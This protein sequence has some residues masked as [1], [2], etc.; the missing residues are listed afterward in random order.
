M[1]ASMNIPSIGGFLSSLLK[2]RMEAKK[3]IK[4][5]SC[6]EYEFK[7][8][9]YIISWKLAW[10]FSY[11]EKASLCIGVFFPRSQSWEMTELGLK[12]LCTWHWQSKSCFCLVLFSH[13]IFSLLK[14][15]GVLKAEKYEPIKCRKRNR[16]L[17]PFGWIWG[18]RNVFTGVIE[19][20]TFRNAEARCCS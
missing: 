4:H 9:T 10:S 17:T 14:I 15:F 3:Y 12:C 5:P 2:I 16:W 20:K 7:Y 19:W 8:L 6:S 1:H 13:C 11:K 18:L